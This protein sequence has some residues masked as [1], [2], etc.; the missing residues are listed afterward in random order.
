MAARVLVLR[1][2]R[3]VLGGYNLVEAKIFNEH[4]KI[5]SANHFHLE[6]TG[7][8]AGDGGLAAS[9]LFRQLSLK[10]GKIFTIK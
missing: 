4:I 8:G 3:D 10:L 2:A 7:P 5:F 1:L 6:Q 9:P